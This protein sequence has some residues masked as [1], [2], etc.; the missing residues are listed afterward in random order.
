[1]TL[2]ALSASFLLGVY[3][4]GRLDAP[5]IALGLLSLTGV[6]T[7]VALALGR[8]SYL[9]AFVLL[10]LVLGVSRIGLE[11]GDST[12]ALLAYH[13]QRPVQMEG[14]VADDPEAA[15]TALRFRF[16]AQRIRADGDWTSESGIVLVTLRPSAEL[17]RTRHPPYVRRGDRLLLAGA[18][19]RPPDLEGFDYPAYLA[20]QGVGS[21]MSFPLVSLLD[22]AHGV[23]ARISSVRREIARSLDAVVPEPESSMGQ[24]LLLGL[25]DG[26][27]EDLVEEFRV[28]GTS[29]LLAISGLHLS[30]V[31]VAVLAVS[32]WAMGRRRQLYLVPPLAVMWGYALLAGMSPSVARAAIMGSVYLAALALGRP[33]SVLPALGLAAA[34]MVAHDPQ[35]LWD[36]SFQLSFAAMAGIATLAE[37]VIA[38]LRPILGNPEERGDS[39]ASLPQSAA[40][41]CAMTVAATVATL[42]LLAFYFQRISLV[43]LPA[44]L[45]TLPALPL[46]LVSQAVAGLT[47]LASTT[48]AQPLGWLAWVTTAYIT[49]VVGLVA[50]LPG[51]SF[52]TG[53]VAP[54]LVWAYYGLLASAYWSRPLWSAAARPLARIRRLRPP[55]ERAVPW[56]ATGLAVAV[57]ALVWSA[58]LSMPDGKL[59]VTFADVG[60]G[61][62]VLITTPGGKTIVVDGGPDPSVAARLVGEK[63]PFWRRSIDLVVLT[64]PHQ[65]H[66]SGLNELL[67]RYEV[68]HILERQF[69][70]DS[71]AYQGWRRAVST[72]GAVVTRAQ[73][74]QTIATD[75]GVLIQVLG[76]P[77]TLIAGSD[78]DVDNAS[79]VL[80]VVYGQVS[81]LL[82]G[83]IFA[84]AEEALIAQ[85]AP[86]GS[87]VMNVPHHG[88]RRSSTDDFLA[89][90][91][92]TA[93]VVSAGE[94]NPFGHPHSETVGA[95][96]MQVP[97]DRLFV[98][99][100]RGNIEFVTDGNWLR[101][102][103]DR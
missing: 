82:T 57:A 32:S 36:V 34:M 44:T 96:L 89:A 75:D 46:V 93:A 78:S 39:P 60:Q 63:L 43:G 80:R 59:H 11:P 29:H 99:S 17:V 84:E 72:E 12:A 10:A 69:P 7:S 54:A 20:R 30:I 95:L 38:R 71:T 83:D 94:D 100:A 65:D 3:V 37:P 47:G 53:R 6:L 27:P 64:H 18:I 91:S 50:R 42:P 2:L 92:P 90:V 21:V 86:L 97:P 25:R 79:V 74:G 81:F 13:G 1:M 76:P 15:G 77:E 51:A 103:S 88:S 9:P 40:L 68:D 98:T 66:V 14:T 22:E 52:E 23:G 58:A 101:V 87:H 8:R 70:F 24:A 73:S 41:V 85:R 56:W 48:I 19:E 26:L 62:M 55:A 67:R 102:E 28:T 33:R 61:D 5:P 4:G 49:G 35:V 45:L 31:L 16:S